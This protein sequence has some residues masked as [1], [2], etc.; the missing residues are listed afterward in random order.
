MPADGLTVTV[1]VGVSLFDGRFGLADRRPQ[2]LTAMGTFPNDALEPAWCHGDVLLQICANSQD[3]VHHALRDLP[4]AP[5]ARSSCAIGWTA[6]W[7]RRVPPVRRATCSASRTAPPTRPAR[8]RPAGVGDRADGEP[9]W[10]VGGSY[11]V[12]RIIRMFL[13]FWDRVTLREQERMIGRRRDTGAPLDGSA[14]ADRPNYAQDP[15]GADHPGRRAYPAGEPADRGNRAAA[16]AAP[17]VQLRPGRRDQRQPRHGPGL[18]L[19]PAGPRAPVRDGPEPAR[20]R[21]DGRLCLAV[22]RRLLLRAAGRADPE[23]WYGQRL[24]SGVT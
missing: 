19:L 3:A 6:S 15:N 4:A 1:S 18:L 14:E 2:R 8:T 12:V 24:L 20:R 11:Q 13:E 22:R 21:A 23:D 9:A 10:A 5:A 17:R 16:P 7:S